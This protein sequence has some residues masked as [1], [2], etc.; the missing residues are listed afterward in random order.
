MTPGVRDR[1]VFS[2]QQ[3]PSVLIKRTE[4]EGE[5][6]RLIGRIEALQIVLIN[7]ARG[8]VYKGF[9]KYLPCFFW[10]RLTSVH[11]FNVTKHGRS[12]RCRR[13]NLRGEGREEGDFKLSGLSLA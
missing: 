2:L 3:V 6:C 5:G 12:E 8:I 7:A 4:R 13:A 11:D 1:G 9:G 10:T